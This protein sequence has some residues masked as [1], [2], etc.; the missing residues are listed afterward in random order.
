VRVPAVPLVGSRPRPDTRLA[1]VSVLGGA[2]RSG[3]DSGPADARAVTASV[4]ERRRAASDVL[5]AGTLACRGCDAPIAIG[6]QSLSLTDQLSCPFCQRRGPVRDFL[7][8][9]A[10][11][12]PAHVVVRVTRPPLADER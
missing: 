4:Q 3:R 1:G 6:A 11:T 5:C 12:R 10:P 7:S 2:D 8:L 9:T